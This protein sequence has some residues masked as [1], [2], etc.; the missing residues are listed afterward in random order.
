MALA[1][2]VLFSMVIMQMRIQLALWHTQAQQYLQAVSLADRVIERIKLK[3]QI[4]D[5]VDRFAVTTH[6]KKHEK[7][8]Y[9]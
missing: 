1:T 3:K 9:K 2:T 7:L 5:S 6:Q 8:P 4:P